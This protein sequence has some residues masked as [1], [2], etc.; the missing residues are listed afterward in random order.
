MYSLQTV[1]YIKFI[2]ATKI[3]IQIWVEEITY[4]EQMAKIQIQNIVNT[5]ENA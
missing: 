4:F 5:L 1:F 3:K 2:T